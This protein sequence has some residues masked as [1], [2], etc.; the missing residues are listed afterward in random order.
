MITRDEADLALQTLAEKFKIKKLAL[1]ASNT[2]IIGFGDGYEL[3]IEYV[4]S[5]KT[6]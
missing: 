1:D 5:E 2:A 3:I 6:L 4:E